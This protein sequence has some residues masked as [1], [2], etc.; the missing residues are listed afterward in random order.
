[1]I[2]LPLSGSRLLSAAL[3]VSTAFSSACSSEGDDPEDRATPGSGDGDSNSAD[4][5]GAGGESGAGTSPDVDSANQ[6]ELP[7]EGATQVLVAV[8]YS[9]Q[10]LRSTDGGKT[11]TQPDVDP[12]VGQQVDP[13]CNPASEECKLL[14]TG[15][16]DKCLLRDVAFHDGLFVA[17]GWKIFTS[18][19][20]LAWTER[21]VDKQQWMGGVEYGNGVWLAVG[22][23]GNVLSSEDGTHWVKAGN[24]TED[25][26]HLRELAFGN[27][28]FLALG[29]YN[30]GDRKGEAI[31]LIAAGPGGFTTIEEAGLGTYVDFRNGQFVATLKQV[32]GQ[33]KP[34]GHASSPDGET[35]TVS[36]APLGPQRLGGVFLRSTEQRIERSEDGVTWEVVAEELP[37]GV[38][39]FAE[40]FVRD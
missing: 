30:S 34:S 21:S 9:G 3:F 31:A 10:K 23:C 13:N 6:S 33:P 12:W 20:G 26:G 22:G 24:A 39:G 32:D 8:G 14:C 25:C 2:C 19:D 38:H 28:S 36:E 11:W 27:G 35:W 7:S 1:M 4:E 17:V 29:A 15:G 18:P 5:G 40:G 16:D 37:G